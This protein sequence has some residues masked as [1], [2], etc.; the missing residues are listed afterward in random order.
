MGIYPATIGEFSTAID[1]VHDVKEILEIIMPKREI[2]EREILEII[3]Q[4]HKDRLSARESHHRC[5][6]K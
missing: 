4:K 1:T 6:R 3:K 5:S 2:N